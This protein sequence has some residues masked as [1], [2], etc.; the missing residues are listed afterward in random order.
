MNGKA[1]ESRHQAV[2]ERLELWKRGIRKDYEK[3]MRFLRGSEE[4]PEAEAYDCLNT[5]I[6]DMLRQWRKKGPPDDVQNWA[7]YL[8]HSAIHVHVQPPRKDVRILVYLPPVADERNPNPLDG[9]YEQPSAE[10]LAIRRETFRKVW[11]ELVRLPEKQVDVV[12][13]WA[14][15]RSFAE[16]AQ[17]LGIAAGRARVLK[18]KALRTLKKKCAA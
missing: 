17:V 3:A 11:A 10:E 7:A 14:L 16:I 9:A 1:K 12:L 13:L 5:A 4:L 18:H 6:A 15:G 2:Q 8:A